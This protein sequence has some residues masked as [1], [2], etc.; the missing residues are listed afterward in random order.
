MCD[1]DWNWLDRCWFQL[2]VG[3]FML[4]TIF[5]CCWRNFDPMKFFGCW[6]PTLMFKDGGCWWQKRPK[7]PPTS[8]NCPKHISSPKS[9]TNIRRFGIS[10]KCLVHLIYH[11]KLSR[12]YFAWAE[13]LAKIFVKFTKGKVKNK[14]NSTA[15]TRANSNLRKTEVLL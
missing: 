14:R 1:A 7:R 6:F 8:K 11:Q 2:D 12:L 4:V 5:W 3:D 13:I 9:V 15:K 10:T